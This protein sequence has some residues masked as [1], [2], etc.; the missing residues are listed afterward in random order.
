SIG[1]ACVGPPPTVVKNAPPPGQTSASQPAPA[2]MQSGGAAAS[3]SVTYKAQ[4]GWV[5]ET[6]SSSMRVAQYRLPKSEGDPEDASLVVF[7]FGQG[8]GGSTQANLERWMGQMEQPDGRPSSEKAKTDTMTVNGMNVSLLD[9][10]GRYTAEM[11]PGEGARHDKPNYR[12]RAA[13]IETPRGPYFVK[14]VGPEKTI[15][16]WDESFLAF[17]RSF[18]AK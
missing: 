17:V 5:T 4:D 9:V 10:G 1:A 14:L 8:Q 3:G 12:M 7:Y 18:E 6:P 13:V 2:P 15:A 11:T 16:R